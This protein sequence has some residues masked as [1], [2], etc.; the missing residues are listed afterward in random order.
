MATVT[1]V[2]RLPAVFAEEGDWVGGRFPDLEVASQ[3]RTH[4][5]AEQNLIEAAQLF[6][7]SWLE[8]NVLD[9][10]RKGCGLGPGHEMPG[11]DASHLTV[12]VE[13][14]AA[15]NGPASHAG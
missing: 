11:T 1:F 8:R 15:R 10:V 13:L 9:A 5:E 14:L 6:I 12:P 3:G 7:E 2:L 4:S